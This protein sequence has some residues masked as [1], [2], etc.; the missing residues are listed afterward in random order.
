LPVF[1]CTIYTAL[2]R[3]SSK[4]QIT[5][6][7]WG[8]LYILDGENYMYYMGKT[9]YVIWGKLYM[10][11]GKNYIYYMGKIILLYGENYIYYMGKIICIIWGKVKRK[12]L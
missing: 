11:Y 3:A 9:K 6:I 1:L 8:K 4:Q 12:A 2:C 10:L 7:I 5:F